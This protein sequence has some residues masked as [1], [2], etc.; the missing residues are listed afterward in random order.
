MNKK[1]KS[2]KVWL[3]KQIKDE[4]LKEGERLLRELKIKK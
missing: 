4:I 3:G 1:Q 2:F